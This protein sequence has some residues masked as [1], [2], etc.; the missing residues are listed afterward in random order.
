M[1]PSIESPKAGNTKWVYA[2]LTVWMVLENSSR[3]MSLLIAFALWN[4]RD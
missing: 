3:L 1:Q 4:R 2:S